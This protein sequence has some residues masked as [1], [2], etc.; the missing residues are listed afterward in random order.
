MISDSELQINTLNQADRHHAYDMVQR[1]T[2]LIIG[3]EFVFC[4]YILLN[5]DKL[6]NVEYSSWLFLISG[7]AG[8]FGILWRFCY[9]QTYHD[10]VHDKKNKFHRA[11]NFFQ[12]VSYRSYIALTGLFLISVLLVGYNYVRRAEQGPVSVKGSTDQLAAEVSKSL[13]A[14]AQSIEKL[15]RDNIIHVEL[16]RSDNAADPTRTQKTT[17]PRTGI[18]KQ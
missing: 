18:S 7:L 9:N 6:T 14:I 4:G 11:W 5:V 3:A 13:L 16:I 15:S 12:I 2:F 17:G 8:L 10:S 1:L